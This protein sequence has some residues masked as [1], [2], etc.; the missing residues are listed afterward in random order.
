VVAEAAD[1][2]DLVIAVAVETVDQVEVLQKLTVLVLKVQ[3]QALEVVK[4]I[5]AE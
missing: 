2:L 3:D 1:T 4:E 5:V